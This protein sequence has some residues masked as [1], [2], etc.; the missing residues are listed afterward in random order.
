MIIFIQLWL[1]LYPTK[2]IYS[3]IDRRLCFI[4]RQI[5]F[6]QPRIYSAQES[7]RVV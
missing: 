2:A 3:D 4:S 6:Y 1:L 7:P 5:S